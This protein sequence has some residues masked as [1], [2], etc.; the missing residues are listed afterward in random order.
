M[1]GSLLSRI[2]EE[3][4]ERLVEKAR[5]SVPGDTRAFRALVLRHKDHVLANCRFLSGS[6][7]EAEDL[8]Q[9][10]FLK[11]YAGLAGFES[12]SRF[13][14]WLHRLKINHCLSWLRKR[15]KEPHLD[16][17]DPKV[18][19]ELP[20]ERDSSIGVD[21]RV[22][23]QECIREILDRMPENLR[24]PL[25]MCDVDGMSYEGIASMLNISLSATKMRIKRAR[26]LFRTSWER[27]CVQ[28]DSAIHAER[29]RQEEIC[30]KR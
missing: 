23:L 22:A 3:S 8:A 13:R 29:Y 2:N 21:D 17:D 4:S 1:V 10:V 28:D 27:Y 6:E 18:R 15:R 12:R 26:E 19:N 25:V 30:E 24:V 20:P 14:T 7:D 5:S 16:I 9:E 11:V